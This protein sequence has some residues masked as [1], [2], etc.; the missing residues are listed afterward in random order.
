MNRKRG[1]ERERDREREK[2]TTKQ[3]RW[4]NRTLYLATRNYHTHHCNHLSF[5]VLSSSSSTFS[6]RRSIL[7]LC[8]L[9]SLF[10]LY[11]SVS[12]SLSLSQFLSSYIS[13]SLSLSPPSTSIS[14]PPTVGELNSP[15]DFAFKFG[16]FPGVGK[17][18]ASIVSNTS[19]LAESSICCV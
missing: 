6:A 5:L 17:W 2:E 16:K 13:T 19:A 10:V 12:Q 7:V 9:S 15:T 11:F 8:T 1:I 3:G 4:T 18:A 14:L